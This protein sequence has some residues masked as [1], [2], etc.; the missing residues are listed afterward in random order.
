PRS[1]A[2]GDVNGDGRPDLV[3]ANDGSNSVSVLLGNGDG[4]FQ[5]QTKYTTLGA[6][7]A[8]VAIGD[9]N[10][11]GRP[12]LVVAYEGPSGASVLRGN[13][14]GTFQA[15]ATYRTGDPP[16]S[17][18]IGDVNGDGRPDLVTADYNNG[19][20]SVLLN[21]PPTIAGPTYTIDT[22]PPAAPGVSLAN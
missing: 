9:V 15:Q 13:G 21:G 1:V 17:V 14:D 10:G 12:D 7:P 5:A 19:A 4:T 2:I 22:T 6:L 18:A 8:S 20:V 11:D 16:V 3:V